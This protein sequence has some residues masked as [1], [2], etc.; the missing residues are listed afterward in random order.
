MVNITQ[1]QHA[2]VRDLLAE[3]GR[4]MS[5]TELVEAFDRLGINHARPSTRSAVD[6]ALAKRKKLV[7]DVERTGHGEWAFRKL[8]R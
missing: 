2:I 6:T 8:Q 3:A 1:A 4:P 5:I 7:G